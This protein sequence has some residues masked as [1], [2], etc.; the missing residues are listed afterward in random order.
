M[1]E[2]SG[3]WKWRRQSAGHAHGPAHRWFAT[4]RHRRNGADGAPEPRKARLSPPARGA[5]ESA[6]VGTWARAWVSPTCDSAC[7]RAPSAFGKREFS[8]S[9]VG[10]LRRTVLGFDRNQI[11]CSD[12]P[13]GHTDVSRRGVRRRGVRRLFPPPSSPI[14]RPLLALELVFSAAGAPAAPSDEQCGGRRNIQRSHLSRCDLR[15]GR[16]AAGYSALKAAFRFRQRCRC[17]HECGEHHEGFHRI[18]L[19]RRCPHLTLVQCT[20]HLIGSNLIWI[21]LAHRGRKPRQHSSESLA[22]TKNRLRTIDACFSIEM[23]D[24]EMLDF[25]GLDADISRRAGDT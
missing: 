11:N 8:A 21:K 15:S 2:S 6:N 9:D 22:P 7:P 14:N 16:D 24:A 13:G 5:T 23:F 1:R 25:Y 10:A 19:S 4:S 12:L 3:P 20:A 18:V 17:E